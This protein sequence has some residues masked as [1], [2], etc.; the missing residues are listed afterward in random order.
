MNQ[1]KSRMMVAQVEIEVSDI[2]KKLSKRV[3]RKL[4]RVIIYNKGRVEVEFE[5]ANPWECLVIKADGWSELLAAIEKNPDTLKLPPEA[6]TRKKCTN[7]FLH[8]R[9]IEPAE[10]RPK[11]G[12]LC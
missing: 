10:L 1:G 6:V 3:G 5:A 8:E 7:C 9:K 2:V 12:D 11:K 4:Y